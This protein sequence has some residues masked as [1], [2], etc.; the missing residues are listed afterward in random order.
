MNSTNPTQTVEEVI[1]QIEASAVVDS[2]NRKIV[3]LTTATGA[4]RHLRMKDSIKLTAI[5]TTLSKITD[6]P[7]YSGFTYNTNVETIVAIANTLQF[8]KGD[9][10]D[11]VPNSL[12]EIFDGDTR[13][14]IIEAYGRLPYLADETFIEVQGELVNVDPEARTR[15]KAGIKPNVE[16]LEALVTSVAVDLHLLGKYE[17][18]QSQVDSAWISATNKMHK[19]EVLDSYKDEIQ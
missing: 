19:A 13:S 10:R 4:N 16:V 2:V 3:A 8:M 9:L 18:K 12:W 11:Q 17:C 5:T 14:E 7:V 6:K 15:A 1:A